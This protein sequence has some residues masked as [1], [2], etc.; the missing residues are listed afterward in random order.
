SFPTRR[1]SD[2]VARE[3]E[4][5]YS[6]YHQYTVRVPRRDEV[7]REM[8]ERGVS[9]MVYYPIPLHLQAV[10]RGLGYREG[11]MPEAERAAREVLSLPMG[12]EL[13]EETQEEVV[14]ALK[15]ALAASRPVAAAGEPR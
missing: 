12:P 15:A 13:K 9:T 5:V 8:R 6:V 14:A 4:A 1:S 7:A 11:S 3:E 10:N 2:L